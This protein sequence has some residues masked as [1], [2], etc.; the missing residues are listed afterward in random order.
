MEEIFCKLILIIGISCY[1]YTHDLDL[2][3]G[4]AGDETN[5]LGAGA[6][7]ILCMHIHDIR[8]REDETS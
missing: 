8:G 2:V 7:Y 5:R 3:H 4:S 1:I 6:A